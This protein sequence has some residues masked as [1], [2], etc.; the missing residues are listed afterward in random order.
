MRCKSSAGEIQQ[1]LMMHHIDDGEGKNRKYYITNQ[2][3]YQRDR[4]E[5]AI[6]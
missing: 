4:R 6:E 1:A 5:E 3:N 2:R